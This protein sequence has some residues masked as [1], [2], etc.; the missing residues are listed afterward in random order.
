MEVI[1]LYTQFVKNL[2]NNFLW[3]PSDVIL[4]QSETVNAMHSLQNL[5]SQSNDFIAKYL[6]STNLK[7]FGFIAELKR[8]CEQL[9]DPNDESLI[10]Y[11]FSGNYTKKS[12]FFDAHLYL[13]VTN[14]FWHIMEHYP[15]RIFLN[16][17][18][19]K[20]QIKI[21]M[22]SDASFFFNIHQSPILNI[23]LAMN[24]LRKIGARIDQELLFTDSKTY[25]LLLNVPFNQ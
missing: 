7:E 14:L 12:N 18:V 8:F 5:I 11:S 9:M 2:D 25:R 15:S 1:K 16:V 13:G 10:V 17:F 19:R 20:N 24:H 4:S 22:D 3:E 21:I 6:A 23:N